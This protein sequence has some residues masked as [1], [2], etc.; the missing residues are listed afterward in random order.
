VD[1]LTMLWAKMGEDGVKDVFMITY[2]H[3]PMMNLTPAADGALPKQQKACDEATPVR[4]HLINSVK[5][6]EGRERE[7]IRGDDIH[8]TAEGYR[9]L[10]DAA[11][12]AMTEAG[13]RR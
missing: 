7:L 3:T 13:A 11:F 8:P 5:L 10:A 12:K 1:T 6:F 9:I 2:P 4:C